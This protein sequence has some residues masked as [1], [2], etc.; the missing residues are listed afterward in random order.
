MQHS[1]LDDLS[2]EMGQ[3]SQFNPRCTPLSH[4]ENFLCVINTIQHCDQNETMD[5][6]LFISSDLIFKL[7]NIFLSWKD[8]A[9]D[10]VLNSPG[11][12]LPMIR[13]SCLFWILSKTWKHIEEALH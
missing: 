10:V 4:F 9:R 7:V 1:F 11:K 6:I 13:F 5:C 2:G 3:H 12:C 8:I